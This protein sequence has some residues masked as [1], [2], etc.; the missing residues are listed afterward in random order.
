MARRWKDAD[1]GEDA[2]EVERRR[3]TLEL[4]REEGG[5]P[6][7]QQPR[8]AK[9]VELEAPWHIVARKGDSIDIRIT[10]FVPGLTTSALRTRLHK[11][12]RVRSHNWSHI[13]HNTPI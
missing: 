11:L 8:G 9:W 3:A 10:D 6:T 1:E 12:K 7:T 13:R 5:E 4:I 2:D